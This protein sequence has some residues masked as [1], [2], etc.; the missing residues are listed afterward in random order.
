MGA[1]ILKASQQ[2]RQITRM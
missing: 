2:W 1:A